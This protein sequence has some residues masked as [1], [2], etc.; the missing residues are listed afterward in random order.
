MKK[1][2]IICTS[3][4]EKYTK[5]ITPIIN[6]LERLEGNLLVVDNNSI[7]YDTFKE[8]FED[9]YKLVY[10]NLCEQHSDKS[11]RDLLELVYNLYK[12][13]KVSIAIDLL[14]D[15]ADVI[16]NEK[17]VDPFWNETAASW[18]VGVALY[19]FKNDEK[20]SFLDIYNKVGY[21]CGAGK[22]ELKK[23]IEENKSDMIS[24]SLDGIV[25]MPSETKGGVLA[26]F[27][28][29]LRTVAFRMQRI[30]IDNDLNVND[31]TAYFVRDYT[32]DFSKEARLIYIFLKRMSSAYN[33]HLNIVLPSIDTYERMDDFKT[34]FNSGPS[35]DVTYYLITSS[36]DYL[37]ELYSSLIESVS[38]VIML[39]NF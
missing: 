27:N 37:V 4:E 20:I 22:E 33:K 1:N 24:L 7:I 38:E 14:N 23:Y 10:L 3:L 11:N 39:N 16:F 26:T 17:S 15:F 28:Q 19:C 8:K 12:D 29:R 30:N 5:G 25:K 36:L 18:F 13:D 35:M 9:K 2:K 21:L 6:E 31:K 32:G 34:E